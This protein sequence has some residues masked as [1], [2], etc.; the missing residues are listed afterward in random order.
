MK[1]LATSH[2]VMTWLSMCPPDKSTS[3]I[4][5]MC[6]IGCTLIVGVIPFIG[7]LAS[8]AFFV[9]FMAADVE[10]SL[11][12]IFQVAA[13]LSMLNVIIVGVINRHHIA[14]IFTELSKIYTKST[15]QE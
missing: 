11:Y 2:Q 8:I 7:L 9:E 12:A 13:E 6:Y 15:E 14:N 3:K 5:R 10:N 4:K 1:P